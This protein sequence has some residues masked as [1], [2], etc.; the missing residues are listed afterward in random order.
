MPPKGHLV[1]RITAAACAAP[2]LLLLLVGCSSSIADGNAGD[3]LSDDPGPLVAA[4]TA[5]SGGVSL[6]LAPKSSLSEGLHLP[7]SIAGGAQTNVML[8]TG[9]TGLVIAQRY[10]GS[11]YTSTGETFSDFTYSSSGNSYSG[12]WVTT[13]VRFLSADSDT[14]IESAPFKVR[15]VTEQCKTGEACTRDQDDITVSMMGIG[16]DRQDPHGTT[17]DPTLNP[18]LNIPGTAKGSAVAPGYVLTPTQVTLGITDA[19]TSGFEFI[20]LDPLPAD[21]GA[22]WQMPTACVSVPTAGVAPQCGGLLVDTGLMYSIVQVPDGFDPPQQ[23]GNGADATR[24]VLQSGQQVVITSP[25]LDRTIYSFTVGDPATGAPDDVAWGH[26]MASHG[27][28]P[29]MNTSLHTLSQL[30][31]AYDAGAGRLGFR[32]HDVRD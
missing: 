5:A 21:Q 31:Y 16:F 10:L 23:Q 28:K 18:F 19:D 9:S 30:D 17:V 27:N 24:S 7:V 32:F 2:I 25:D 26:H 20:Q 3:L 29:F 22:D 1:H 15:M 4:T 11:D 8:D 14:N 13:T 6:T 12:E